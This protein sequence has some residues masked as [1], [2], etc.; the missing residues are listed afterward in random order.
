MGNSI[1]ERRFDSVIFGIDNIIL[2]TESKKAI[3]KNNLDG[4]K[5]ITLTAR[6]QRAKFFLCML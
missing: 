1:D 3:K 6:T 5:S 4:V 2:Y